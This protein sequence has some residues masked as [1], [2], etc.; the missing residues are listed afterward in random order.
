MKKSGQFLELI[1]IS[2]ISGLLVYGV[3]SWLSSLDWSG[4]MDL[5]P[6]IF[7]FIPFLFILYILPIVGALPSIWLVTNQILGSAPTIGKIYR[8]N[9]KG[10]KVN[11]FG[12]KS[13]PPLQSS[14]L[15]HDQTP[16]TKSPE[17]NE[18]P[19]NSKNCPDFFI[20]NYCK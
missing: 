7:T 13:I 2:F 19:I 9:R 8:M 6:N 17:I 5:G 14:E 18:I 20:P 4:G 3:W 11:I 1:G 15:N 16:Y 10:M 12:P